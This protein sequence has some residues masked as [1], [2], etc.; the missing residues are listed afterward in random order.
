MVPRALLPGVLRQ[1][2]RQRL[3]LPL[4]KIP[5]PAC[6]QTPRLR[7]TSVIMQRPSGVTFT[8][9]V[10]VLTTIL[11]TIGTLTGTLPALPSGSSAS[12]EMMTTFVHASVFAGAIIG[13]IFVFLYWKGYSWMRWVVMIYCLFPLASLV[14]IQKTFA[15]SP[16]SGASVII[17]VLL[18]I[19]LL[20]YLNTEP[21]RAWFNGPKTETV[22]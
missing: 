6:A 3:P 21:V 19:F 22:V 11:G 1:N 15:I 13:L 14:S 5:A 12:T 9:A 20:Y 17:N 16:I 2:G 4:Q 7:Y 18:A 10:M 8:A